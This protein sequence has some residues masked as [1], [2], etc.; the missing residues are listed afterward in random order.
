MY[1]LSMYVECKY[2]LRMY[3]GDFLMINKYIFLF[4]FNYMTTKPSGNCEFLT[5]FLF[6]QALSNVG[7]ICIF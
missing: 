6:K 1:L 2:L 4:I 3:V 5:M 7:L